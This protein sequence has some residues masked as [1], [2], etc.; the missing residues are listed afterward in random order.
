[1]SRITARSD[2][3]GSHSG[4]FAPASRPS[5]PHAGE[6]DRTASTIPVAD[7]SACLYLPT[8]EQRWQK[9]PSRGP[10]IHTNGDLPETGSE[11]PDFTLTKGDLSDVSLADFAGRKKIP[12]IVPSLDTGVCAASAR[13]FNERAAATASS[14]PTVPWR[15]C[16]A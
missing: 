5:P 4:R 3:L 10:P 6:P 8:Q 11:A 2:S 15:G 12:N 1:M 9:E 13:A 14:S 7:F 16:S